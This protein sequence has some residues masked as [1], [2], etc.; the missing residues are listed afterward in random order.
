MRDV[1][2]IYLI[3]G[4]Q[5]WLYIRIVSKF[6]KVRLSGRGVLRGCFTKAPQD[7][8]VQP[9]LEATVAEGLHFTTRHL[10][11]R[12]AP[13]RSLSKVPLLNYAWAL[14]LACM[15]PGYVTYVT[16]IMVE[17]LGPVDPTS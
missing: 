15:T 1:Q 12:P 8:N 11:V 16:K 7:S 10:P 9:R 4:S 5:T 6:E 13:F 3:S 14:C 17:K 2:F